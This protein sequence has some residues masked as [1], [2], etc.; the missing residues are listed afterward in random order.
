MALSEPS[1]AMSDRFAY[2]R[3]PFQIGQHISD[4]DAP[5]TDL[6]YGHLLNFGVSY[7]VSLH[8]SRH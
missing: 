6:E 1:S 5:L 2:Q 8:H 4:R 7:P 3:P